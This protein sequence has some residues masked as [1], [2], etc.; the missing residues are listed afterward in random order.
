MFKQMVKYFYILFLIGIITL[1]IT[2]LIVIITTINNITTEKE[3]AALE[4]VDCILILGAGI[5]GNTPSPMLE[6]RLL[7]GMSLYK[8]KVS[9]KY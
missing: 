9:K 8:N 3:V 1:L 5:R 2:N 7:K 4:D 6:D